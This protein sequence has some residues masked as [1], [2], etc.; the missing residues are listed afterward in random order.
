MTVRIIALTVAL[1]LSASTAAFSQSKFNRPINECKSQ[2]ERCAAARHDG[3]CQYQVNW[4]RT[5]L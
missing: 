3:T 2:R 5:C 4:R 1:M